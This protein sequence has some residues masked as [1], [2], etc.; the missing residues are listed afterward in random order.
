MISC[1]PHRSSSDTKSSHAQSVTPHIQRLR[2]VLDD[3]RTCRVIQ[4]LK[5][6]FLCQARM[7]LVEAAIHVAVAK[8]AVEG[9]VVLSA[10]VCTSRARH[11]GSVRP[12]HR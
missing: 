2:P 7:R 5:L 6:V 11:K 12:L 4:A 10:K 8:L 9:L 1:S 3:P